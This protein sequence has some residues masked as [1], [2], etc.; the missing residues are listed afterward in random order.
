MPTDRSP[1]RPVGISRC[2]A[3]E[4]VVELGAGTCTIS[5]SL[6]P[7]GLPA[8]RLVVVEIVPET[9]DHVRVALPGAHGLRGDAFDVP[10]VLPR[11]WH[12][13]IGTVIRRVPLLT[14]ARQRRFVEAVDSVAPGRG[15]LPETFASPR[16]GRIDVRKTERD[17]RQAAPA[18]AH[19]AGQAGRA[20]APCLDPVRPGL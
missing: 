4:L 3:A 6:L 1:D 8:T 13:R 10:K 14:L 19:R 9:V 5:R 20:S 15:V 11:D 16:L 12:G 2:A 17:A 18:S 7:A